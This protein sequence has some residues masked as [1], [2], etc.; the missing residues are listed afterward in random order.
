M[1]NTTNIVNKSLQQESETDTCQSRQF[2][3]TCVSSFSPVQP[4]NTEELRKWLAQAFPASRSQSQEISTP[5]MTS[6]T[7]GP[8]RSMLFALYDQESH[9]LKTSQACLALDISG[10]SFPTWPRSG[11]MLNGECF[12]LPE[13]EPRIKESAFSLLPT[14]A[15]SEYK[16]TS[17]KRYLGSP[18]FKSGKMVEGLRVG[19][20]CPTYLSPLFADWVMDFPS[21]WTDLKP[22]AM[23]NYQK[24]LERHGKHCNE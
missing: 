23:H 11:T 10:E 15:A 17:T 18:H 19:P 14:I 24:W 13:S 8:L 21:G 20:N 5:K 12:Q 3:E 16:G 2:S 1:S 22:L 9:G 4:S 7:C 6:E